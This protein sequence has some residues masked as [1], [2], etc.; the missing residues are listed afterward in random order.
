MR[1]FLEEL[2]ELLSAICTDFDFLLIT[3]DL[4]IHVVNPKDNYVNELNALFDTFGQCLYA[5]EPT[6]SQVHT[7]D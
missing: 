7:L 5:K 2:S 1:H 3:G 4:N 6:L